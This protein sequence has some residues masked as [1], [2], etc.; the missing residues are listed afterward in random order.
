M[1]KVLIII[2]VQKGFAEK[3][4]MHVVDFIRSLLQK[5]RFDVI[6]QSRWENYMGSKYETDLG[7]DSVGNSAETELLIPEHSDH[8]ITRTCYSCMCDK[9]RRLINK[10][11]DIYVVGLET[12]A[13]VLA[14][15]FDL[16]DEGYK[17]HVYRKGVGTN[18]KNLEG[19][20]L[21]LIERQFGKKVLI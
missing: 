8:V 6:V 11:D 20:A 13:C 21:A 14:T 4:T 18:A 3:K 10:D 15:L 1:S 12:D 19:P 2:D 5:E 16:W 7:Y 17:F 9:L